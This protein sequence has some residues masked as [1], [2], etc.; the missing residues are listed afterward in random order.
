MLGTRGSAV[1]RSTVGS[2]GLGWLGFA[3]GQGVLGLVWL[4]LG[5]TGWLRPPIVAM[6]C[7]LGWLLL[8]AAALLF[9]GR[10]PSVAGSPRAEGSGR[11]APR[12]WYSYVAVAIALVC[13]LSGAIA[14]LPSSVGDAL[15]V[16]LVMPKV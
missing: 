2:W 6:L 8:P 9:R 11:P 4:G 10:E 7:G 14:L 16:Y 5:L 12:S 13:V 1:V 15:K 3:L